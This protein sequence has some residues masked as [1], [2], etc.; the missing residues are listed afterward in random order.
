MWVYIRIDK[1]RKVNKYSIPATFLGP[2]PDKYLFAVRRNIRFF[3]SQS[4][5]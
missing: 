2:K 1:G 5:T 3:A 4:N